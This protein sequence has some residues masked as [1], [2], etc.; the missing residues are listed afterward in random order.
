MISV[1]SVFKVPRYFSRSCVA[2]TVSRMKSKYLV[3]LLEDFRV[4]GQGESLRA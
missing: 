1:P 2:E 3:V 4:R